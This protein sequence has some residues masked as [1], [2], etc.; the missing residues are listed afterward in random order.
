MLDSFFGV[1]AEEQRCAGGEEEWDYT[2]AAT[3]SLAEKQEVGLD[4]F[5]EI[6]VKEQE[7]MLDSLV[8]IVLACSAIGKAWGYTFLVNMNL[9]EG[10]VSN[11]LS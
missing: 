8:G 11:H 10:L 7:V 4:S 3:A 1:A 6:V 5:F 2:L 9:T